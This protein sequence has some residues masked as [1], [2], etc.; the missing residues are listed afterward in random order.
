MACPRSTRGKGVDKAVRAA[1]M[2]GVMVCCLLLRIEGGRASPGNSEQRGRMRTRRAVPIG[3]AAILVGSQG[4]NAQSAEERAP[5]AVGLRAVIQTR[6]R[7]LDVG[8]PVWLEFSIVN[9]SDRPLKLSVPGLKGES[10][11]V[12]QGLPLEHVFSGKAFEG[13]LIESLASGGKWEQ[14]VEYQPPAAAPQVLLAPRASVGTMVEVSRYY[15]QLASAGRY[16]LQWKP[17]EGAVASN[18]LV[19]EI[20]PRKQAIIQTDLGEMTL[21]LFYEDA[22]ET[23]ANFLELA[24][25]GFYNGL[26][27]HRIEPGYFTQGGDP[28]GNGTGIRPDGRKLP[29]EFAERPQA[30]GMVSMARLE[31]EP[32]S[33]SCQFFICNTRMP[34]WDGKY[35][36]FGQL[37]GE[38][39]FET[40][41]KLMGS[42]LDENG[43]PKRTI[44][45]R[46]V[47]VVNVPEERPTGQTPAPE[48]KASP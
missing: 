43:R 30:R 17:Y 19:I 15:P 29:A 11:A 18:V 20:A 28:N 23:V 7:T 25:S 14:P 35:T 22:P 2:A 10:A 6:E 36:I 31:S 16:R 45:M 1:R 48:A 4:L 26:T 47:R 5:D 44:V 24:R 40:L 9:D 27:F 3:L 34:Q 21:Q 46:S 13:L 42:P 38:A 37:V 33:A 12:F 32:D 39:S 41:D 8:K